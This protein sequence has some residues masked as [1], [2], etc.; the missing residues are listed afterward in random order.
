LAAER[1][2]RTT[3]HYKQKKFNISREAS[4]GYASLVALLADERFLGVKVVA[5]DTQAREKRAKAMWRECLAIIGWYDLS[6]Q[7]VLD[8]I[9]DA[10]CQ[11]LASHWSFYLDLLMCTPW[12]KRNEMADVEGTGL[13]TDDDAHNMAADQR[14]Q[15]DPDMTD[16]HHKLTKETGNRVLTQVLGFKFSHHRYDE[17]DLK[18]VEQNPEAASIELFYVTA[19]LIRE[20]L[21]RTVDILSHLTPD[22]SAMESLARKYKLQTQQDIRNLGGNALVM[23]AALPDDES[24]LTGATDGKPESD[25]PKP[26]TELPEQKI[27]LCEALLAIGQ[28][29]SAFYILSR[30][31][32]IA[33]Y[34][35]RVAMLV[36]RLA[37]FSVKPAYDSVQAAR[38]QDM[39]PPAPNYRTFFPFG[40]PEIVNTLH[41]PE[42][43]DTERRRFRFFY[44]EWHT[45]LKRCHRPE[46]VI[47]MIHPLIGI[48]GA[49]AAADV[50]V[51]V[52]LC[53]IGLYHMELDVS[54]QHS[55]SS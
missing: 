42:P 48:V 18:G 35:E 25:A 23:A 47:D 52:W 31:P 7:R 14:S 20:G 29:S 22:D 5:D 46:E 8:L 16:F 49:R 9:L 51:L 6:P 13:V 15:D 34:S 44:D 26:R 19:I 3:A 53:R 54:G 43:V 32:I 33:Q 2:K 12:S 45:S 36:M 38:N 10:F 17:R 27:Q 41:C 4:E 24:I 1:R 21:V 11:N 39:P 55:K 40:E 37:R 50:A 28:L 30:W